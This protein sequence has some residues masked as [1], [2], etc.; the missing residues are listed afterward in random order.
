MTGE[1]PRTPQCEAGPSADLLPGAPALDAS[2][3]S[4]A[5]TAERAKG[6][7]RASFGGLTD[8]PALML[9]MKYEATTEDPR[10]RAL[11]ASTTSASTSD[12]IGTPAESQVCI[13]LSQQEAAPTHDHAVAFFSCSAAAAAISSAHASQVHF[14]R[15][16]APN[17]PHH[18][19]APPPL[20]PAGCARPCPSLP[21]VHQTSCVRSPI[22]T[23]SRTT[24][25]PW[26]CAT[27]PSL[28]PGA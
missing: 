1:A 17:I 9:D 16:V 24:P 6:K 3:S 22:C 4:A 10:W 20:L 23:S 25:P 14:P 26:Y 18:G 15:F 11:S 28:L 7:A 2:V 5:K 27:L 19:V 8:V 12:T 21:C 13:P